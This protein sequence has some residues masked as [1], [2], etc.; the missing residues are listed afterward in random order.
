MPDSSPDEEEKE[1]S[2]D[3]K[4]ERAS[5][6]L[7][8][9]DD[10]AL[11]EESEKFPKS[12]VYLKPTDDPEHP[13]DKE[14]GTPVKVLDERRVA[15][16]QY[17]SINEVSLEVQGKNGRTRR[18]EG[19]I[20]DYSA[21]SIITDAEGGRYQRSHCEN[22]LKTHRLL[23]K[24]GIPVF[25]TF[26]LEKDKPRILM[27]NGNSDETILVNV[28]NE[29]TTKLEEHGE[30][31]L[32]DVPNY[33]EWTDELFSI[34]EASVIN[35]VKLDDDCPFFIVN[36]KSHD[37]KTIIGDLD[38]VSVYGGSDAVE[39][40]MGNYYRRNTSEIMIKAAL[41]FIRN[42]VKEE[43]VKQLQDKLRTR[44]MEYDKLNNITR[45]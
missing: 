18:Y 24:A 2:K 3:K 34:I 7:T 37:V 35:G 29:G 33:D 43:M 4:I 16:G 45:S 13:F 38:R 9:E 39:E 41:T 25:Q 17:G 5:I 20:K 22:V 42:N 28:W 6:M 27:T 12:E 36:K 21:S 23:Q 31:R 15:M 14:K 1:R 44:L 19:V 10:A 40:V 11:F 32:D 30:K 26:R 8:E